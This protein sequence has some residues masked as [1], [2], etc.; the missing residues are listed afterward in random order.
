MEKNKWLAVAVLLSSLLISVAML[1]VNANDENRF[2]RTSITELDNA[3]TTQQKIIEKK[4]QELN[5]YKTKADSFQ[6]KIM[7]YSKLYREAEEKLKSILNTIP[8][9]WPAA[10]RISA[11][12]GNRSDP[13]TGREAFHEGLDIAAT[14]GSSIKAAADGRV[15]FAG[16]KSG[17]GNVV[18]ISHKNNLST[19]YGHASK[20]LV[21]A[22]QTVKRGEV[23]AKIGSTGRSTG[24]HLH[25]EVLFNNSPVDPLKYLAR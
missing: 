12:Y 1:L 18:I 21:K 2:L 15:T 5:G 4:D 17:Y 3:Y 14:Y 6:Q 24:P 10:G 16:A 22:G 9:L 8:S 19:L 7:E 20:L 25:F 13:F 23:I 11:R